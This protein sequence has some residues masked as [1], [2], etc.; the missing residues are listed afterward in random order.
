MALAALVLVPAGAAF[1]DDV[2]EWLGLGSVDVER[3][4]G[5]PRTRSGRWSTSSAHPS[6]SP[7]PSGAPASRRSS[8]TSSATRR[9]SASTAA[10]VTLVYDEGDT[11]LAQ[12]PGA[13]DEQLLTKIA[14]PGTQ[15]QRLPDGIFFSGRDHAYL[16]RRPDGEVATDEARLAGNM[17]VTQRGDVLLRLEAPDLTPERARSLLP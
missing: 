3:C 14:G 8:P 5:C 9:R 1:G 15:I 4:R 10:V 16:Y 17:F 6:R 12:L 13:L 11:L 2:L 7:R